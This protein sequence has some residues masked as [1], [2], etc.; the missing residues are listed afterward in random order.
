MAA[1]T[2]QAKL[3]QSQTLPWESGSSNEPSSWCQTWQ[4]AKAEQ[5]LM[6][7]DTELGFDLCV[8]EAIE[9]SAS[10]EMAGILFTTTDT[11]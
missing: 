10:N 4:M 8:R 6:R 2:K 5:G 11:G 9:S 3:E 7:S 1:A